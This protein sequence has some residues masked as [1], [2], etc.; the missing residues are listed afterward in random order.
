MF[1]VGTET[2][3]K[4]KGYWVFHCVSL[5]LMPPFRGLRGGIRSN[6][7]KIII[8]SIKEK[9]EKSTGKSLWPVSLGEISGCSVV[10]RTFGLSISEGNSTDMRSWWKV[11]CIINHTSH[12]WALVRSWQLDKTQTPSSYWIQVHLQ[13]FYNWVHGRKCPFF[14]TEEGIFVFNISAHHH[15]KEMGS[16]FKL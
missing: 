9:V 16:L 14:L 10:P 15:K 2:R 4:T 1:C 8:H 11:K 3:I 5:D 7:E 13:W 12:Q 6:A